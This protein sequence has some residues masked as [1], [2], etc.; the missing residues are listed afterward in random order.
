MH[1]ILKPIWKY[2]ISLFHDVNLIHLFWMDD[3]CISQYVA[4]KL[5]VIS[6]LNI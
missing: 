6:R 4:T 3:L 2:I 1:N 5:F